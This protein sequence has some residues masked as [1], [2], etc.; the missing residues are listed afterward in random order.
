VHVDV[1]QA[2]LGHVHLDL[3]YLVVAADEDPA[4]PP[5]ES[6]EVAW[7]TWEAAEEIADEGLQGALRT[8]HTLGDIS[9]GRASGDE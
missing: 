5:E 8:A 6:Q 9:S 3:R 4:P 1:H 7:F 2:A